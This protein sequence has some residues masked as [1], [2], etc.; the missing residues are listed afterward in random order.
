MPKKQLYANLDPD[1]SVKL[2]FVNRSGEWQKCNKPEWVE[3][4]IETKSDIG[5]F[6]AVNFENVETKLY[7]GELE[8]LDKDV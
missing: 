5:D 8:Q 1:G 6:V 7:G 2:Y 4:L 3:V